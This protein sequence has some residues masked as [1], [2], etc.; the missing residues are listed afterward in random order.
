MIAGSMGVFFQWRAFAVVCQMMRCLV[1]V[2]FFFF[3]Q[4]CEFGVFDREHDKLLYES[5]QLPLLKGGCAFVL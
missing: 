2:G 3:I 5:L 4:M 1:C